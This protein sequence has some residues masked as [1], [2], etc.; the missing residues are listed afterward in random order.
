MSSEPPSPFRPQRRARA[1][2]PFATRYRIIWWVGALLPAI[3]VGLELVGLLKIGDFPLLTPINTLFASVLVCSA[4]SFSQ[5]RD[6]MTML[7]DLAF[8]LLLSLTQVTLIGA[9]AYWRATSFP[10]PT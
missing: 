4:A 1:R 6:A 7:M 2:P 3:T 10:L 5:R 8:V 9:L